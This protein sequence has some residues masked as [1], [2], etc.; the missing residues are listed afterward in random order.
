MRER[1]VAAVV[2]LLVVVVVIVIVVVRSDNATISIAA[3]EYL[4]NIEILKSREKS[5]KNEAA[6]RP[7]RRRR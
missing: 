4:G 6:A 2:V 3:R 7:R 5:G 1:A